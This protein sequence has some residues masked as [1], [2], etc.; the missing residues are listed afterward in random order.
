M[1]NFDRE[2]QQTART[3]PLKR[4]I[5]DGPFARTSDGEDT[6]GEDSDLNLYHQSEKKRRLSPEQVKFLEKSFEVENKLEPE[7]K[8]ELAK[9][10]GLQPRQIAIWFQNRRARYKTKQIEKEY[11]SLKANYDRLKVDY[12]SLYKEKETL[13]NEVEKLMKNLADRE[14]KEQNSNIETILQFEE[15]NPEIGTL[16]KVN[17][18]GSEGI[19]IPTS[20]KQAEDAS[21]AK[22]DVFDSES[23][24]CIDANQSSTLLVE[25]SSTI[26]RD[27]DQQSDYSQD[28]EEHL[29][30]SNNLLL[31]Q[32]PPTFNNFLKLTGDVSY[33]P[34]ASSCNYSLVD[35][36]PFWSWL[37]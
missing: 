26:M 21:S 33:D 30:M 27:L 32:T 29:M 2:S 37:Y 22:S 31:P 19:L 10:L 11:D 8:V 23:P 34:N 20:T 13:Q 25:A 16:G 12:D 5:N 24:P 28:E 6:G 36:Q 17:Q 4:N 1:M 7:R 35:E 9:Q 18:N 3:L 15:L 14:G